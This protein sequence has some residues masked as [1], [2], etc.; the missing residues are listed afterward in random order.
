MVA[1]V[2]TTSEIIA[3]A[4]LVVT[5]I[6]SL[7]NGRRGA[8]TD[9]AEQARQNAEL[10]VKLGTAINGISEIRVDIRSLKSDIAAQGQAIARVEA[11]T[12]SAHKRIDE[13]EKLFHQAH[14]PA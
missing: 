4:A 5:I 6:V 9:A 2:M 11:S 1:D 3:L 10:S 14:P 8:K 13:L 12:E 7:T